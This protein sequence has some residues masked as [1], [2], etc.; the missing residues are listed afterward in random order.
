MRHAGSVYPCKQGFH[1]PA[2]RHDEPWS[3]LRERLENEAALLRARGR[4]GGAGLVDRLVPEEE[5][6]E[7]ERPRAVLAGGP[8]AA[9]PLLD[10]EQAVEQL[11]RGERRVDHGRPVEERRLLADSVRLRLAQRRHLDEVYPVLRR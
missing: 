5:K 2:T 7:V 4:D 8:D 3:Q 1:D 6:V 10:G 9:E 11:S